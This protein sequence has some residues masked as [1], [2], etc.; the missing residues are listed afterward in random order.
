M[1]LP[2]GTTFGTNAKITD[3]PNSAATQPII[4]TPTATLNG[5]P[6]PA[7]WSI[8]TVGQT[9]T[10]NI[11]DNYVVP[12]GTDSVIHIVAQDPGQGRRRQR[13]QPE[14]HQPGERHL[15]GQHQP[16]PQLEPGQHARSSSR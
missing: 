10:V 9:I 5:T 16:H 6:L 8:N 3:T 7:G 15:D 14:P 12:I 2:K 13:A 4:G 1:T 11:P